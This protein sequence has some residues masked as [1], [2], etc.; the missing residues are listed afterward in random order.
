MQRLGGLGNQHLSLIPRAWAFF[1]AQN[2]F[3]GQNCGTRFC[4]TSLG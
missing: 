4:D 1:A 3:K 2:Q